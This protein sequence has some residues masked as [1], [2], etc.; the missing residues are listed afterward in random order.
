MKKIII[1]VCSF[2]LQFS[3]S[4]LIND[5]HLVILP[6]PQSDK[7][8]RYEYRK[9]LLQLILDK[10]EV[11]YKQKDTVVFS[12][13]LMTQERAIKEIDDGSPLVT[14][15]GT[16]SSPAREEALNPIRIPVEKGLVGYRILLINKA[17]KEQFD[18]IKTLDELKK[19]SACFKKDWVDI[20]ILEGNGIKIESS[21]NYEGLFQ[22][23]DSGRCQW[24]PRGV[25]EVF[26]EYN[27]RKEQFKNMITADKIALYYVLPVYFFVAKSNHEL[28]ERLEKG[29]NK[30]IQDG[31]FD[32]LFYK[33]H[34]TFIKDAD[35]ENRRIIE[36]KNPILPKEVPLDKNSYWVKFN[37]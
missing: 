24:F 14:V 29:F 4:S 26:I 7:D 25:N 33:F 12:A 3:A 23:L 5:S 37:H 22:M 6:R 30:I 27:T 21:N 11:E 8:G 34:G 31:S 32:K 2:F 13:D 20:A 9:Q 15:I 18:K 16:S 19:Y 1:L 36:L 35:L 28:K 10:T 17:N